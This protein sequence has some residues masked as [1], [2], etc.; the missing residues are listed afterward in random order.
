MAESK[1]FTTVAI[2]TFLSLATIV[3]MQVLELMTLSFF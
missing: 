1:L 3:A 2:V